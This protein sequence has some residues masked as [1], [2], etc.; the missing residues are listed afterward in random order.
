M[1]SFRPLLAIP[2]FLALLFTV[3][4]ADDTTNKDSSNKDSSSDSSGAHHYK[5][6]DPGST[7][8]GP[9]HPGLFNR[10]FHVLHLSGDKK[11]SE[12]KKTEAKLPTW[13]HLAIG[14]TIE[15]K[16]LKLSESRQMKVTLK[17]ENRSK[18]F[19]QLEFPTTQRIEV[20]VKN[21]EGKIIEHWSEDQAFNNEPGVVSINS[22]ERLEYTASVATR[23]MTAGGT[24]TVEGFFPNYESLHS[25]T[26]ITPEK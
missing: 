12:E 11:A 5:R 23:E 25:V 24:Y 6:G 7:P 26:T 8:G 1:K 13:N 19:V 2:A 17:L 22:G 9:E 10:V 21:Q 18:K 16:P 4:A 14:M 3:R 15:P 20:L